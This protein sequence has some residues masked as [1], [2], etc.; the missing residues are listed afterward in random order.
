M[1]STQHQQQR[2][3]KGE[4]KE[5]EAYKETGGQSIARTDRKK[6]AIVDDNLGLS[7]LYATILK[8]HGHE[9]VFR[10]NTGE[11]LV[12]A[13]EEGKLSDVQVVVVDY[14]MTGINGLAAARTVIARYPQI[15]VIIASADDD[16]EDEARNSGF[17]FLKKPFLLERLPEYVLSL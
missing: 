4:G 1:Q 10:A 5:A 11:G 15:G 2:K 17:L 6:I 14:R 9:V 12:R 3:E 13:A 16:V 8:L 7:G